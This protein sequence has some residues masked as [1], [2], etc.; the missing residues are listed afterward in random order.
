M[1][2]TAIIHLFVCLSLCNQTK[3]QDIYGVVS[4]GNITDLYTPVFAVTDN[5]FGGVITVNLLA[6]NDTSNGPVYQPNVEIDESV[7]VSCVTLTPYHPGDAIIEFADE[8]LPRGELQADIFFNVSEQGRVVEVQCS[9]ESTMMPGD[10]TNY[11]NVTT[12]QG[13]TGFVVVKKSPIV[14]FCDPVIQVPYAEAIKTSTVKVKLSE[15]VDSYDVIVSCA[16]VGVVD[17][18][19][20]LWVSF[21]DEVVSPGMDSVTMRYSIRRYGSVVLV[22]CM[23]NSTQGNQYVPSTSAGPQTTFVL[24][25]GSVQLVPTVSNVHTPTFSAY[26]VLS[27]TLRPNEGDITFV[28]NLVPVNT[29]EFAQETIDN[30]SCVFEQ[31]SGVTT[32]SP[33]FA[34]PCPT[35]ANSTCPTTEASPVSDAP[36]ITQI[37]PWTLLTSEFVFQEGEVFKVVHAQLKSPLRFPQGRP[38]AHMLRCV[39]CQL[40]S[41]VH[42]RLRCAGHPVRGRTGSNSECFGHSSNFNISA[43][44]LQGPLTSFLSPSP[45]SLH[46]FE[47]VINYGAFLGLQETELLNPAYVE[48]S[49]CPC[50]LFES[51][52]DTDCCCDMDCSAVDIS[53]FT[54][55]EG[56]EGGDFSPYPTTSAIPHPS[57]DRTGGRFSAFQVSNSP[58]LGLYYNTIRP[59]G[60]LSRSIRSNPRPSYRRPPAL[61]IRPPVNWISKKALALSVRGRVISQISVR[62]LAE[63]H[64]DRVIQGGRQ[65][66]GWRRGGGTTTRCGWDDG[67]TVPPIPTLNDDTKDCDNVVLDVDYQLF[68]RGS[69]VVSVEVTILLG[70]VPLPETTSIPRPRTPH[71]RRHPSRTKATTVSVSSTVTPRD[72]DAI[73]PSQRPNWS[74][75]LMTYWCL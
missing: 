13:P 2:K 71:S 21:D 48:V 69:A 35:D 17:A 34:T 19:L 42:Q 7:L 41:K 1:L 37:S 38:G 49:P 24:D 9:G 10:S 50:D 53:L 70:S 27:D 56:V 29:T 25:S 58:H 65:H 30:P 74:Q 64:A 15:P 63:R 36:N 61:R 73:L 26:L 20:S 67:F 55:T 39:R 66:G 8:V 32:Q 46:H 14:S 6:V 60:H 59:E 52:C 62:V 40:E 12:S 68:W 11:F 23:A 45:P 33:T 51:K 43:Y 28:C 5:D 72:V 16:I 4:V 31:P 47:H 57:I 22:S 44:S 54:C 75:T 18:N 3:S